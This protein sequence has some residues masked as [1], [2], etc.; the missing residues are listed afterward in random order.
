MHLGT[1]VENENSRLI[2]VIM[3]GHESLRQTITESLVSK[4]QHEEVRTRVF[5][6]EEAVKAHTTQIE[7]L[8]RKTG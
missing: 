7:E 1:L 3:E 8:Q 6:L 2:N 4:E 5:A